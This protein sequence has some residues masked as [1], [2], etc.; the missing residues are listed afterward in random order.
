VVVVGDFNMP[1]I[2]WVRGWS[3]REGER[4]LIDTVEDKFWSQMVT[5]PTHR[6]GNILDLCLVSSVELVS[7]VEVVAPL[8]SSDHYGV[9]VN[10][11][12]M[13]GGDGSSKEEVPDWAKAD[14]DALSDRLGEVDWMTEFGQLDGLECM[15]RFYEVLDTITKECV[16]TRLRRTKN[17]PLWMNRNIMRMLRRKRRLWRA[18]TGEGVYREAT[19]TSELTTT[20]RRS[21]RNRLGGPRGSWRRTWQG[22]PRRTLRSSSPT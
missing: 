1:G 17:R 2:D 13:T 14:M 5:V 19:R 6:L 11:M 4:M 18:Y 20:Y 16:P 8:G 12:G 10:L 9:E 22:R 15:D 7:G 21:S 3:A